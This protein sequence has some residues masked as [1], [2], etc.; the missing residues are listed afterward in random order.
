MAKKTKPVNRRA[1]D[2]VAQEIAYRGGK[3]R[4][5]ADREDLWA[6]Y[7]MLGLMVAIFGAIGLLSWFAR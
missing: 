4:R 2:M 1:H 3:R 7:G 6:Y 5:A